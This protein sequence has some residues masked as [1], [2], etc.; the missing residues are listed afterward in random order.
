VTALQFGKISREEAILTDVYKIGKVVPVFTTMSVP[1]EQYD[2]YNFIL[3]GFLVRHF[4]ISI[5]PE[6]NL[7]YFL[8]EKGKKVAIPY[9]YEEIN[10]D[11]RAYVLYKQKVNTQQ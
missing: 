2:Q 8:A 9:G 3:Q 6:K 11:L 4:F 10:L 7:P 5:S 1:K